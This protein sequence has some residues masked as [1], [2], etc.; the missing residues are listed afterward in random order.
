[1]PT[2][3]SCHCCGEK[4]PEP[5]D[6][7]YDGK[8]YKTCFECWVN[9]C[10][11]P[12]NKEKR[13]WKRKKY[14]RH[15]CWPTVG[16]SEVKALL[17]VKFAQLAAG[18]KA[19][20]AFKAALAEA[21]A[22][23]DEASTAI[24]KFQHKA[25]AEVALHQTALYEAALAYKAADATS[26]AALTKAGAVWEAA[27]GEA[28]PETLDKTEAVIGEADAVYTAAIGKAEAKLRAALK[29]S[30]ATFKAAIVE[31][32][33][34][35]ARQDIAA[36]FQASWPKALDAYLAGVARARV[37]YM[38]AIIEAMQTINHLLKS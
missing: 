14:A 5:M 15:T 35:T 18:D 2:T 28:E 10:H 20:A 26:K 8:L 27:K 24:A 30:E 6:D 36:A 1:M 31:A 29:E 34:L 23:M 21:G 11:L 33:T 17:A 4:S 38:T 22:A 37:A 19:D 16:L 7:R 3:P 9:Q 12:S 13:C 32:E 25:E